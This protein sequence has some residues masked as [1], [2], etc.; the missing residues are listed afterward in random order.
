MSKTME[1]CRWESAIIQANQLKFP[2]DYKAFKCETAGESHDFGRGSHT[3]KTYTMEMPKI[4]GCS[5]EARYNHC[6]TCKKVMN[7]VITVLSND[8][9]MAYR[10]WFIKHGEMC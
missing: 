6:E 8:M 3:L 9:G 4:E 2:G 5:V 1:E 10:R 7:Q